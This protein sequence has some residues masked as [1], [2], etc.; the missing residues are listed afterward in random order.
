MDEAMSYFFPPLSSRYSALE[1]V[2][3]RVRLRRDWTAR[4]PSRRPA[5]AAAAASCDD[6][7]DGRS[8]A[9]AATTYLAHGLFNFLSFRLNVPPTWPLFS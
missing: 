8:T 7:A 2:C 6:N 1:E 3:C 5:A 4:P 9:A